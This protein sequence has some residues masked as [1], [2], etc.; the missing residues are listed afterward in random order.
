MV[1]EVVPPGPL[2]GSVGF[3]AE[4]KALEKLAFALSMVPGTDGS[5]ECIVK[6]PRTTRVRF[7]ADVETWE[8]QCED[9]S[10]VAC[11]GRD[12]GKLQVAARIGRGAAVGICSLA[13]TAAEWCCAERLLHAP[14]LTV[15]RPEEHCNAALGT[16]RTTFNGTDITDGSAMESDIVGKLATGAV[17]EVLELQVLV[18]E[19][20]VRGRISAP[21]VG[22]ISLWNMSGSMKWVTICDPCD[23]KAPV[24]FG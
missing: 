24:V 5:D 15:A 12:L 6:T 22:W 4:L 9:A 13:S 3:E 20:R 11:K 7:S 17:V 10:P 23:C 8:V 2:T 19:D 16:Y 18:A 21:A 14:A 1:V